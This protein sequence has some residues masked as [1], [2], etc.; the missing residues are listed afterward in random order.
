MSRNAE[1]A[2]GRFSHLIGDP[3][4]VGTGWMA[5]QALS[6]FGDTGEFQESYRHGRFFPKVTNR[7]ITAPG[8]TDDQGTRTDWETSTWEFPRVGKGRLVSQ[9]SGG[10]GSLSDRVSESRAAT[11]GRRRTRAPNGRKR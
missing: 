10:E 8:Y 4:V 6:H 5:D 1:F 7:K 3:G 11:G 2:S 9:E